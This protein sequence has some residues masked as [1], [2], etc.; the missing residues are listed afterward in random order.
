MSEVEFSCVIA[1]G[2]R[3]RF[4]R[5]SD[6]RSVAFSYHTLQ[7]I[8]LAPLSDF[9]NLEALSLY[10]NQLRSLDLSPLKGCRKLRVI[11]AS[12]N[13]IGKIDLSPL[14][15]CVNLEV[16][17][18]GA[19][20]LEEVDLKPLSNLADLRKVRFDNNRIS[21]MDLRPLSAA[22]NLSF[23]DLSTNKLNAIDLWP[24]ASCIQLD[25]LHLYGNNLSKVDVTPLLLLGDPA[26]IYLDEQTEIITH[27]GFEE[28]VV[29][30]DENKV[31]ER[32]GRTLNSTEAINLDND[33]WDR[34]RKLIPMIRKK[35]S[36]NGDLLIQLLLL[37]L[38]NIQELGLYDGP[39]DN[40]LDHISNDANLEIAREQ[41]YDRMLTLVE[42][43]LERNGSTLFIDVDRLST[44][45]ASKLIPLV[46]EKKMREI[47]Q[48]TLSVKEDWVDL[49]PLWLTSYGFAILKSLGI[50]ELGVT[51]STFRKVRR[52]FKKAGLKIRT[53]Q[54][55]SAKFPR[56]SREMKCHI[57]GLADSE[58][59]RRVIASRA[60]AIDLRPIV[61]LSST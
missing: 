55:K 35:L 56:L 23:V 38:V 41:V 10:S 22:Q 7:D 34:I 54:K 60:G 29:P 50:T 1:G 8:D 46:L 20:G 49:R 37:K 57:L 32:K 5:F 27:P 14:S 26:R 52:A 36:G 3:K 4:Q 24:L 61:P 40:I 47:D 43:Q 30:K 21:S 28:C 53:T 59:S 19:N 25:K 16:L 6:E 42:E 58:K 12:L 18:F 17:D 15:D 13:F 31:E 44:T 39:L 45:R 9:E 33:G 48:V 2:V 51:K 11:R